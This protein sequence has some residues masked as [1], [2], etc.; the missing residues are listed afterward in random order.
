MMLSNISLKLLTVF[1]FFSLQIFITDD[2]FGFS[3]NNSDSIS[4]FDKAQIIIDGYPLFFVRGIR[5]FPAAK[6][7]DQIENRIESIAGDTSLSPES[8]DIV[9]GDISD[10]LVLNKY[11]ILN[12]Y[13][14]DAE[15]E[16][17]S[18]E[19]IA[20][21]FKE[22]IV[23]S[24]YSYRYERKPKTLII[25]TVYA[26]VTT[27]LTIL[28]L[29]LLNLGT[30]KINLVLEKKLKA[31]IDTLEHKSYRLIKSRQLWETIR[32][33]V[34]ASKF[35]LQLILIFVLAEFILGLYPWTRSISVSLSELF[36]NPLNTIGIAIID[37]LPN[38]AFLIILFI[39]I[40]YILKFIKI[41]FDGIGRGNIKI[42]GFEPDWANPT[43]KIIKILIII[44]AVVVAYPYIPGSDSDA[45]KGISIFMGVLFSLG[46]SSMIGNITAGYSM[47]YRRTFRIGDI[48]K[49]NDYT[50]EVTEIKLLITKLKTFKNEEIVVPNSLILNSNIVNYTSALS[51]TKGVIL[52]TTVGI[53][54][55]TPWRQVEGMLILAAE[56]TEGILQVPEPFIIQKSLGD[57]AINYE[58]NVFCSDPA[59]MMKSY[60]NLHRNILDVFNENNVQIM[61]PSYKDDPV[62]PK[63][64]PKDQWFTPVVGKTDNSKGKP[65]IEKQE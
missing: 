13:N 30:K 38:L 51:T 44:L 23:K 39:I 6:R 9:H 36:L 43:F 14:V 60:T 8:I 18:R 61:T 11:I 42:S 47:T 31:K 1:L 58:L 29:F 12:I 59:N 25:R 49:I 33:L 28:I 48:V 64:V 37:Y 19:V 10:K 34:K 35:L 32:D 54:Y 62:E 20:P 2:T 55:E 17:V 57:F 4:I 45:F 26:A 3:R 27:V 52:H 21:I 7:A 15:L 24:I 5:L 50:G 22:K 16:G 41:V 53:G 56:R 40:R 63:V 65:V 46:S